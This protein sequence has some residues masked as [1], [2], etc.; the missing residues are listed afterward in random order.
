MCNYNFI[1]AEFELEDKVFPVHI[2][3]I[4]YDKT[5]NMFLVEIPEQSYSIGAEA[6]YKYAVFNEKG[7]ES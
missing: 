2:D 1:S 5:R 4:R 7:E 6:T 3:R